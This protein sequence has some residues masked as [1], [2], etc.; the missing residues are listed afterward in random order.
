LGYT[1]EKD[2]PLTWNGKTGQH[3]KGKSYLWR[4]G[5]KEEK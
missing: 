1:G 5:A 4:I 3:I 2:L